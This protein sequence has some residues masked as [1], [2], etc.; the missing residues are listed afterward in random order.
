MQ[1][2]TFTVLVSRAVFIVFKYKIYNRNKKLIKKKNLQTLNQ[3][4]H[5]SMNQYRA[6]SQYSTNSIYNFHLDNKIKNIISEFYT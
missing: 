1:H 6:V 3:Y 4:L 5:K 2:T